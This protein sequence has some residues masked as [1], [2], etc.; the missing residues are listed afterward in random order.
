MLPSVFVTLIYTR[1]RR[2]P[3]FTGRDVQLDT[4]RSKLQN[5]DKGKQ[6]VVVR[7]EVAGMGGVGKTQLVT[8]YCYRNFPSQYG[9]VIWL[10]AETADTLVADYRSLLSDMAVDVVGDAVVAATATAV[11]IHGGVGGGGSGVTASAATSSADNSTGDTMNKSTDEI[12]SEVKTRLFR[13]RVPWLLV[14]DNLEDH[15]LLNE[16][17]PR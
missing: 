15:N 11:G 9:L 13:S 6:R 5:Q 8:E 12:V 4:L 2:N 14:F 3:N 7:V 16:F 17:V 10:N 1:P